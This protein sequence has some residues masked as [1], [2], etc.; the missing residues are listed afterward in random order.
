M[1]KLLSILLLFISLGA[2]AQ[3]YDTL[4]TGSKPYGNQLYLSPTGL[5]IGGA[6]SA[7]FRIIGTKKYVDSLLALKAPVSPSGSY[8]QNNPSLPQS[9]NIN[10]DGYANIAGTTQ[11]AGRKFN[12]KD[13]MSFNI[14]TQ[15]SGYT[16]SRQVAQFGGYSSDGGLSGTSN[17]NMNLT[18]TNRLES[19]SLD[20]ARS[21][22]DVKGK[23]T[24]DDLAIKALP[25]GSST[26]KLLTID[27]TGNVKQLAQPVPADLTPYQLK[28]E[29]AQPNGYAS[30][31]PSGKVPLTQIDDALLGAVNYRGVYNAAT[32]TPALPDAASGNKGYY[33]IVSTAGTQFSLNL[34][35]G[36]WVIS[37]GSVYGKVD[38]NNSVTSV[39]GRTGAVVVTKADVLLGNVEN[40]TDLNKVVSTATQ[41]ALN[42]KANLAGGNTFE[43]VQILNSTPNIKPAFTEIA[44]KGRYVNILN[45]DGNVIL[46]RQIAYWNGTSFIATDLV[47]SGFNSGSN[48]TGSSIGSLNGHYAGLNNTGNNIGTINGFYAGLNN[49]GNN[50]GAINGFSAGSTNTGS[51]IG[52]IIGFNSA[53]NNIG[54]NIGTINGFYAGSNNTGGNIGALI[55]LNTGRF[56]TGNNVG[57]ITGFNTGLFNTGNNVGVISG[58]NSGSYNSGSNSNIIGYNSYGSFIQNTAGIKTFDYSAINTTA[59]TITINSHG[60]GGAGSYCN[61]FFTQGT[62]AITGLVN[63]NIIQV[64]IID[65]NTLLY[66][67]TFAN[68]GSRFTNNITDAGTGTGHSFTP[69]VTYNNLNILGADV[70]PT[71]SNQTWLGSDFTTQTFIQG[72]TIVNTKTDNGVDK[73]QVNGTA[74]FSTA[75]LASQAPTWGQTTTYADNAAKLKGYTVAT[76]PAGVVGAMAYVTDATAPTYN[77]N[78]VGGGSIKIPVFFNGTNWVSH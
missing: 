30:L 38:N 51:G 61:L 7:K 66:L 18:V 15:A 65:A 76:L 12:V 52:S 68:G 75:T 73:L 14:L 74:S 45:N 43:G 26:D 44:G 32:N 55:G 50:I 40:T 56:N 78:V 3:T 72:A 57:S 71:G 34:A 17:I 70:I 69:S 63:T 1:K 31:N 53:S 67:E 11:I 22:L 41:T 23:I 46:K 59:K 39:A 9:A 8:I 48:N 25:T 21:L 20:D 4:P 19:P 33:Y 60:F 58:Y 28:S 16:A 42:L 62:S 24:A 77:A 49:T 29:K 35:V 37:N 36:D 6:G 27:G 5:I 54:S 64:K 47:A 10:I 13:Y 2:F